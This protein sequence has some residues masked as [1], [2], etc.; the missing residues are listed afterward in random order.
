MMTGVAHP[1]S[2]PQHVT[3]SRLG[4]LRWTELRVF[5]IF[6]AWVVSCPEPGIGAAFARASRHAAGR[7]RLLGDRLP[8]AGH[9]RAEVVTV[10]ASSA[11]A[12]ALDDLAA[13]DATPERLGAAT[14]LLDGLSGAVEEFLGSLS[15]VADG[16]SLRTLPLVVADLG[17]DRAVFRALGDLMG[18][19]VDRFV[20]QQSSQHLARFVA[21]GGP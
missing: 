17:V 13:A 6:G 15:P 16:P 10:P 1:P 9:L 12:A 4:N 3:V 7:A 20:H 11:F 2:P 21:T 14:A 5:E 8:A 18:A 19:D